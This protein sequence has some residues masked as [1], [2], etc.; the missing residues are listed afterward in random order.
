VQ[1]KGKFWG[2]QRMFCSYFPKFS[3]KAFTRQTF[4]L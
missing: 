1:E 3:Q 4:S 2:V